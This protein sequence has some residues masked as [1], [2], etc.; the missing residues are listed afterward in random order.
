[1]PEFVC[2]TS[3]L[4]Y[5]HQLGRL[6]ILAALAGTVIVPSAVTAELN[7]GRAKGVDLPDL[8]RLGWIQER[9]PAE[10][11][12]AALIADLGAGEAGVLLLALEATDPVVILDDRLARRR[13]EA[14]DL[15]LTGTL[16][17]LLS[18]KRVGLISAITPEIE[19][20][21]A[22]GF[23]LSARAVEA[24]LQDAGESPLP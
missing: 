19:A 3:P 17:L 18:A 9:R 5:L 13:A 15:R 11:A 10:P 20:L 8:S 2:N 16:G 1:M 21:R 7:H 6:E 12:D 23:R 14:L 4:Q 22:L 24:V